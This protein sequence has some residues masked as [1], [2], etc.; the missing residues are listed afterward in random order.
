MVQA[1]QDRH[2]TY[3]A[4]AMPGLVRW[5]FGE[6]VAEPLLWPRAVAVGAV[7]AQH[8]GEVPRAADERVIPACAAPA[9]QEACAG[10]V[11]SWGTVGRAQDRDPAGRRDGHERGPARAVV[12]ADA[13]AGPHTEGGGPAERPGDPRVRGVARRADM[14]DPARGQLA[15]AEREQRPAG[16]VGD[17]EEIAGPDVR[18]VVA[19]ECRPRLP[20]RLRRGG[21]A[22]GALDGALGDAEPQLPQRAADARGTPAR[23]L[24]RHA[25]K[26][27]DGRRRERWPARPR[28]RLPPPAQQRVGLDEEQG[29]PPGADPAGAQHQERPL[30]RCHG[31][32]LDAPAQHHRLLT[33]ERVLGEHLPPGA[34]QVRPGPRQVRRRRPRPEARGAGLPHRSEA[35]DQPTTTPAQPQHGCALAVSPTTRWGNPSSHPAPAI[36]AAR[37]GRSASTTPL[38]NMPGWI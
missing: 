16:A 33:P 31:R 10:R 30:R 25:A 17:G 38:R 13:V 24:A 29:L 37:S 19:Q 4:G 15:D 2:R 14:D 22:Q 26:Q 1:A 6:G 21:T 5:R 12:V 18:G 9:A 11:G 23:V 34:H 36:V 27:G 20:A 3:R 35:P 8:T 7:L 32:A 28:A